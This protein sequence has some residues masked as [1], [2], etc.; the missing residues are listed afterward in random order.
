MTLRELLN[1]YPNGLDWEIVVYNDRMLLESKPIK[2]TA[3][4]VD[5]TGMK[6]YLKY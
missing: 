1:K 2:G 4:G 5:G 6:I 3:F